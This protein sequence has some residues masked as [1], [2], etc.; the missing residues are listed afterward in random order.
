MKSIRDTSN[1]LMTTLLRSVMAAALLYCASSHALDPQALREDLSGS[2]RDIADRMRDDARK[3][4]DVL[5]F[6]ELQEGMTV[7]EVYAAGGYYTFVLSRAVGDNGT[8]YA[9]NSPRALRY[10]EDR[11]D[12]TQG[13]ALAGKIEQG[14]L[15]NVIRVDR[16][17]QDTEL[18]DASVDFIL[19]SQILHDYYNGSPARAHG[20]LVELH[21]LLKPGGIVGIIDHTGA[22]GNDNRRLHRMLKTQ[23]IEAVTRAGFI[24]E[25]ESDLL[26]NPDDNPRRSIFD[27]LLNRGTDQFLLRLRK[28]GVQ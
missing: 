23:A 3:P 4:V 24:V 16:A 9:Q 20:L 17:I 11:T 15:T 13:D 5:T 8:V 28:P 21:R 25:A 22:E 27:P 14:R 12:I 6:L 18:P 26:A 2:D 10:D 19:V 7:L 1:G